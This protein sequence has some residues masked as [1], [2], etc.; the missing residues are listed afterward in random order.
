[1]S[2][3][4]TQLR[5]NFHRLETPQSTVWFSYR[6]PIAFVWMGERCVRENE[7]GPTTGKHLNAI[8]GGSKEAKAARL[9]SGVFEAELEKATR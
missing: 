8:D 6:T 4:L 1:M 2:L 9:S 3:T 5:P 7:W